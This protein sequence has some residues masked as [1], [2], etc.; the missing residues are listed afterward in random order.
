M[1]EFSPSKFR[2]TCL[3][4]SGLIMT[5]S[6]HKIPKVNV[7]CNSL[8]SLQIYNDYEWFQA[9]IFGAELRR[10]RRKKIKEMRIELKNAKNE[11]WNSLWM[12]SVMMEKETSKPLSWKITLSYHIFLASYWRR[13]F[14]KKNDTSLEGH[15][16]ALIL[17]A[18]VVHHCRFWN[19]V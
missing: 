7:N 3:Q 15:L 12:L 4:Y 5:K 18:Y 8:Y 13:E 16:S 9:H 19:M 17:S 11:K 14:H 10:W 1:L 2:H 6:V